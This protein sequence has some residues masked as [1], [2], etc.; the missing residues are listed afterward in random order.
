ML[1]FKFRIK[2]IITTG[3]KGRNQQI[4]INRIVLILS[5]LKYLKNVYKNLDNY[6]V[7]CNM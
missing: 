2:D 3:G 5:D 1:K 7:A 4:M 6:S